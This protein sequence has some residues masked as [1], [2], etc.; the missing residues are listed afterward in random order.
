MTAMFF[1]CFLIG[2]RFGGV[3]RIYSVRMAGGK[4]LQSQEEPKICSLSIKKRSDQFRLSRR[5]RK[6]C[7]IFNPS[8]FRCAKR[9]LSSPAQPAVFHGSVNLLA[10]WVL[11]LLQ[12]QL[13]TIEV[14]SL[15][16]RVL[17]LNSGIACSGPIFLAGRGGSRNNEKDS[18][19][20]GPEKSPATGPQAI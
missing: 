5:T 4:S 20:E 14:G 2:V 8:R 1:L 6:K 19:S 13:M 12:A 7:R 18:R 9:N 17:A 16:T 3:Q 10:S 11:D 15:R